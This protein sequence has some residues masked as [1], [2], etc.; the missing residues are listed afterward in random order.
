MSENIL[1]NEKDRDENY[2]S[3]RNASQREAVGRAAVNVVFFN[4]TRS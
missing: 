2:K 3:S 4:S 1:D